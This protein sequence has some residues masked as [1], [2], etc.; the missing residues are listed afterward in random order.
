MTEVTEEEHRKKIIKLLIKGV[1]VV[2]VIITITIGI[3]T[4]SGN[5]QTKPAA[6]LSSD[7]KD[8]AESTASNFITQAGTFG[9]SESAISSASFSY[10]S[11]LLTENSGS[12]NN[13]SF[14]LSRSE[15][16]RKNV[17][18]F[19]DPNGKI[20]TSESDI[21]NLD[22][23]SPDWSGQI[24]SYS[25]SGIT[26]EVKGFTVID[27]RNILNVQVSFTSTINIFKSSEALS[28]SSTTWTHYTGNTFETVNVALSQHNGMWLV[29]SVDQ[30]ADSPYLLNTWANPDW[31]VA[32]PN[33]S[34]LTKA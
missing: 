21:K 3:V 17:V 8:L 24:A 13:E 14:G 5:P 4:L 23:Y 26:T 15:S 16:F 11:E 29:Y 20:S 30:L 7:D 33:I 9:L 31:K 27:G 18:P 1:S 28:T 19:V 34:S 10:A 32:S 22:K 6:Q 2:V 25:V 12:Y